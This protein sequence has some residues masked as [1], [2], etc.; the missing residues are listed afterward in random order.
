MIP[1]YHH[2]S[3]VKA[4]ALG[5]TQKMCS[6]ATS[7]LSSESGRARGTCCSNLL[8]IN[9][10]HRWTRVTL[11]PFN[12]LPC[13]ITPLI[14]YL[15]FKD[16]DFPWLI[17]FTKGH[18]LIYP[19]STMSTMSYLGCKMPN[20]CLASRHIAISASH[21]T[22]TAVQLWKSRRIYPTTTGVFPSKNG[23]F[24]GNK[25]WDFSLFQMFLHFRIF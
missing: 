23:K 12:S 6:R 2:S 14:D 5:H 10:C 18:L 4:Q 8:E 1:L 9:E 7:P 19:M 15:P 21:P 17:V 24:D 20:Q 25:L 16:G 13:K 11:W 3:D 22:W